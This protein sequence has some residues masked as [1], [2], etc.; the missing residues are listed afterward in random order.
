MRA[1]RRGGQGA[2][3]KVIRLFSCLPEDSKPRL[4]YICHTQ[5]QTLDQFEM[6]DQQQSGVWA[7]PATPSQSINQSID[8]SIKK[9]EK[10]ADLLRRHGASL[11]ASS[12]SCRLSSS[13]LC[14]LVSCCCR[15]SSSTWLGAW[16]HAT[17]SRRS[18]LCGL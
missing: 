13:I 14:G 12:P 9:R 7:E 6:Y 16:E 5:L 3:L 1:I 8:Q 11:F 4:S 17:R 10:E 15:V 2:H 18:P